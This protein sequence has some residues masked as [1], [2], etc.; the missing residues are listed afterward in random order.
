MRILGQAC[1]P[2]AQMAFEDINNNLNILPDYILQ[3]HH[4]NSKVGL[5]W[6]F[7]S[8]KKVKHFLVSSR[9]RF[10][11]TIRIT[12]QS[13][14]KTNSSFR[15]LACDDDHCGSVAGLELDCCRRF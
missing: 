7:Q 1:L 11:T 2:A 4:Y 14:N 5:C 8:H 9:S 10:Q 13:S 12:L 6:H 15:M 3:L